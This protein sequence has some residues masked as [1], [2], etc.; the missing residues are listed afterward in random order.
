MKEMNDER[1][2][3]LV[4]GWGAEGLE[5]GKGKVMVLCYFGLSAQNAVQVKTKWW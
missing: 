3:Q 5:V 1:V 2:G 4:P